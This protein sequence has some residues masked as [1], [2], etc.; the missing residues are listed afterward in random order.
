P[1]TTAATAC[2]V[3][4]ANFSVPLTAPPTRPAAAVPM[5]PPTL[6]ASF[7]VVVRTLA[8]VSTTFS[9]TCP[10][11]SVAA[12]VLSFTVS[13]TPGWVVVFIVFLLL[14]LI[15][16]NV[17]R[18]ANSPASTML[19][20]SVGCRLDR[21]SHVV[22]HAGHAV[23]VGGELGDEAF[24]GFVLGDTTHGNDAVRRGNRRVKCAGR[25]MRQQRRLDLGRD[26]GVI[27]LLAD[28]RVGRGR[29]L[30]NR[31]LVVDR[32]DIINVFGV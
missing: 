2:S 23:D 29:R 10:V 27:N 24:F 25:T 16:S 20:C 1:P 32:F 12:M 7:T 30:G 5:F 31:H 9:T 28:G 19:T 21:D 14:W 3:P 26:G 4:T 6:A 18:L 22:D 13:I 17:D 8:V 15:V 11:P